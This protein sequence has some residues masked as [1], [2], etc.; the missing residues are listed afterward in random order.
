MLTVACEKVHLTKDSST[1]HEI[2]QLDVRGAVNKC[3]ENRHH[4]YMV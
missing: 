3:A 1:V 4:F 2:F